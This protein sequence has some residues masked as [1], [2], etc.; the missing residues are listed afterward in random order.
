MTDKE[1]R[2]KILHLGM[3]EEL[4]FYYGGYRIHITKQRVL[5]M[6]GSEMVSYRV[7]RRNIYGEEATSCELVN[8]VMRFIKRGFSK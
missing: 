8:E 2:S 1:I 6:D 7:E 4:N 3:W 5:C